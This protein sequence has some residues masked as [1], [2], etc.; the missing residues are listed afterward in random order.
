MWGREIVLNQIKSKTKRFFVL[1]IVFIV[2]AAILIGLG[3]I[4]SS[5]ES[6]LGPGIVFCVFAAILLLFA[7]PLLLFGISRKKHPEKQRYLRKHPEVLEYAD[8]LYATMEY[9]NDHLII[10]NRLFAFKTDL[11]R[12]VMREHL[13]SVYVFVQYYN[14]VPSSVSLVVQTVNDQ[15]NIPIK[16]KEKDSYK[17][18]FM[19]LAKACRFCRPGYGNQ[20]YVTYMRQMWEAAEKKKHGGFNH[21]LS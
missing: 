11:T 4:V 21:T 20:D 12:I 10:S 13:L 9:Q 3:V 17:D 8:E 5:G 1:S 14:G 6:D 19:I 18:D 7:I 2:L 16:F 15:F